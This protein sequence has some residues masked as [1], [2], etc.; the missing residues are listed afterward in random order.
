MQRLL[1]GALLLIALFFENS[2][3]KDNIVLK[4]AKIELNRYM[5]E[6]KTKDKPP[7]YISYQIADNNSMRITASFG[8]IVSDDS[9]HNRSLDVDLRV[10]DYNFDNSHIIRGE[11]SFFSSR[12]GAVDLPIEDNED[13]LRNAIWYAT[14]GEYKAAIEKYQK[15]VTNKAVKVKEEDTSADFSREEPYKFIEET[16]TFN[17]N[18]EYWRNVVRN[19]SELFAKEDI[20]FDGSVFFSM[21]VTTKYF[22]STEGTEILQ[23]QPYFRVF[24]SGRTKADDG[25]N[26]P[27]Y[28]SFF[29]FTP[30]GLPN[31]EFLLNKAKALIQLLKDLRTAPLVTSYSGPAIMSGE[32][33]G[34]FFHEIFGHRVEGDR[35]K[36]PNDAQTYKSSLGEKIL[37]EFL[38]VTFDPTSKLLNGREISGYYQYDDQGVKSQSVK[39]VENGVFKNFLISRSPIEK[40][41]KSNGHGRKQ[42]GYSAVSRQSNL[43][44]RANETVPVS[45]LKDKLRKECKEQNK[46]FGLYFEKVQGG[47][48][49]TGR[50]IPNAFNVN[51]LVVY[52][53]FTDGRAD[54][55][56]RGVDL[57]GT[58]LTTFSK[59][60]A[61]G[62]DYGIFNGI[63]GAESGGVPVSA[64]SPTLMVSFIEVQKK[65]KSQAK[66]PILPAPSEIQQP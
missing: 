52:K 43:I 20:I 17:V 3:A 53:I 22:I 54:E 46:E 11:T 2:S 18:R 24:I 27:L 44:V 15:V 4:S 45:E 59:I 5:T 29:S 35:L 60:V 61:A 48:T 19:V 47:F 65:S 26:L 12:R 64:S 7:Y 40:F 51:P 13:A 62:D 49:F 39:C 6:L 8:K 38:N 55:L 42:T 36:D 14:D 50:S 23:F 32:A 9:S 41:N 16:K 25:M 56:V 1:L 33:S 58:P 34:V 66:P 10:G 37:P 57:I 28:E 30:E 21:D 31:E 63:C